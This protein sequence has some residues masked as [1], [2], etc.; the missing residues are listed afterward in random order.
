MSAYK[1]IHLKKN[2]QLLLALLSHSRLF[3]CPHSSLG[4]YNQQNTAISTCKFFPHPAPLMGCTEPE[5]NPTHTFHV[6]GLREEPHE[7]PYFSSRNG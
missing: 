5:A 1:R 2:Q 4:P 7:K 6:P 3:L